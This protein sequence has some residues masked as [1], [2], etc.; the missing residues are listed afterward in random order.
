MQILTQQMKGLC[1]MSA[2]LK[3]GNGKISAEKYRDHGNDYVEIAA[4]GKF[5]DGE[6]GSYEGS[7]ASVEDIWDVMTTL[8]YNLISCGASLVISLVHNDFTD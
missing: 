7:A 1:K 6:G 3:V 4:E 2:Y 5:N 8:L